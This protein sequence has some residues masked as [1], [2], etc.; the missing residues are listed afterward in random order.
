MAWRTH[1]GPRGTLATL[2]GATVFLGAFAGCIERP[3]AS[4]SP[5]TQSG[6]TEE[7][8]NEG[9]DKVDLLM[10]IDNSNSMK[11]NQANIGQQLGSLIKTLTDPPCIDPT[12]TAGMN[13][14]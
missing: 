3:I 13:P 5:R 6:I 11:D 4:I 9:V 1:F 10:M 8:R 7:I 12:T 14:H 2:A